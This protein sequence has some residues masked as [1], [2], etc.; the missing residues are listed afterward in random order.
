MT[1]TITS[2]VITAREQT[3]AARV[4]EPQFHLPRSLHVEQP[5][6][7]S[8]EGL[9]INLKDGKRILDASRYLHSPPALS[10]PCIN[11]PCTRPSLLFTKLD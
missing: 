4:K 1:T 2:S 11:T 7:E 8:A 3:E 9:Y 6:V 5:I 10:N